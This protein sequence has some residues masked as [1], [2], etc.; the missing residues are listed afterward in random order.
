MTLWRKSRLVARLAAVCLALA[1]VG[2][3]APPTFATPSAKPPQADAGRAAVADPD[4]AL[5]AGWRKSSDVLV[6]GAGDA[7]GFHLYVA[8]EKDAYAWSTL[9]T[10]RSSAL[11]LGVW[12]GQVCVTGSGRYAVAVYAPAMAANKP[13]L[14]NGG[15]LAAVVDIATGTAR[16]LA[17]GVQLAYFNPACGPGDRVL[18]TRAI[19]ADGRETDLLAGDAVSATVTGTRRIHAQLT[20]PAPAPDGDYGIVNGSLVRV[21]VTGSLRQVA[22]PSGRPYAVVATAHN[23]IDLLSGKGG[24][25][26]AERWSAG[27]LRPL[28]SAAVG[29]LQLFGLPGGRSALVGA[30]GAVGRAAELTTVPADRQVEAISTQGHL[31]AERVLSRA[32]PRGATGASRTATGGQVA[33][34]DVTVRATGSGRVSTGTIATGRAP[35]LDAIPVTGKPAGTGQARVAP[36]DDEGTPRC[37]VGRNDPRIQALQPSANMVEWAADQAVHGRLTVG[38]PANHLR[39][40][41]PAYSPQGLFPLRALAGGGTVPAQLLL[42]I[43]AQET[44]LAEASWHA[45]PGDTGNPL[46]SD[47]YGNRR[48]DGSSDID[49]INYP[50]ADC[51]YGIGQVTTGM[52]VG[53]TTFTHNQQIAI[54]TDY[55]ANIAASLNIL[56]EKWNQ[57]YNDPGGRTWLND[58]SPRYIENW[59]LAI[60]AYNSGFHPSGE[61]GANNGHWGVGW[62]N[63]PANPIYPYDRHRFLDD[64]DD[65]AHPWNWS[66][67]EKIMG[68]VEVPQRQGGD[69]AYSTPTFGTA[70]NDQLYLPN[71]E[72]PPWPRWFCTAAN[73]CDR[74]VPAD[75]D[76]C[77]AESDAC[78]WHGH[79]DIATCASD[80]ATE[81]LAYPAG[82]GEPV[83]DRVY[84]RSCDTL[85]YGSD[86]FITSG[87]VPIVYDLNDPGDY[88]L[89]CSMHPPNGKFT[90]RTGSPPDIYA[91]LGQIDLHQIGAGYKGHMWFTHVYRPIDGIPATSN[92]NHQVTATWSPDLEGTGHR[93]YD[94][95]AHLPSH[96]G[97]TENAEYVVWRDRTTQGTPGT[98]E[99][100][101]GTGSIFDEQGEDK[102]VYLG[103]YDLYPG[104]R[105]QLN[106]L[107]DGQSDGTVD[108]AFDAMAFIPIQ[109]TGHQCRDP[110]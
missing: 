77:P 46:V 78:W 47:Y 44:N 76:P 6:T 73:A 108:I 13:S 80:C 62:F 75:D 84:P 10:L 107:G 99:I 100:D 83:I 21:T 48:T 23:G 52:A 49:V 25:A 70:A 54:A 30:T 64:Y 50:G 65:A 71:N 55:A 22:R 53:E 11:D 41:L 81:R 2:L 69:D 36:L 66:Y 85:D 4:A 37:A 58:G 14:R 7:T 68:W 56:I 97:E 16:T 27:S 51:G 105:V 39:T 92:A 32:V 86:E 45:V 79:L 61:A 28:G 20:T 67:P 96:G 87:L 74:Q 29:R 24:Q 57:L 110:F 40:G 33:P 26:Y 95:V 89:G 12:A 38:R 82:S 72:A 15:G 34:V 60:W 94:I 104:A 109:G 5:G 18:L 91:D 93:R 1:T 101:Q 19:G 98:C 9:A 8:R 103:N 90:L 35:T 59:Y 43:L 106:N 88:A 31:V 63:N 42:A 102:W 3:A 17:T